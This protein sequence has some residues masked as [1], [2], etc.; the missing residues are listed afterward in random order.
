MENFFFKSLQFRITFLH[1]ISKI[2]RCILQ[3]WFKLILAMCGWWRDLKV[4]SAILGC[5]TT[6]SAPFEPHSWI[7]PHPPR[8]HAKMQ[9]LCVFYVTIWGQKPVLKN[10]TPGLKWRRYGMLCSK[11]LCNPLFDFFR[12]LDNSANIRFSI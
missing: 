2:W 8:N 1:H 12:N 5:T 6:V 11:A 9:F 4:P 7:E 10:R 3:F